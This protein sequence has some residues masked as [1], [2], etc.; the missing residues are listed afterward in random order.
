MLSNSQNKISMLNIKLQNLPSYAKLFVGITATLMLFVCLWAIIIFYVD[1]GLVD[2]NNLPAYLQQDQ[3]AEEMPADINQIY[4]D[5]EVIADDSLAE[6]APD[7]DSNFSEDTIVD[8]NP[9][10][11]AEKF[12]QSEEADEVD[13]PSDTA[14]ADESFDKQEKLRHN[15]GLAHTH[16]NGQTLLYFVIG[17]LFMFTTTKESIKKTVYLIFGIAVLTHAIG[18]SGEGFHWFFDNILALSGIT[19]LLVIPYMCFLIIIDLFKG[20]EE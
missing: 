17:F 1:K 7:W 9:V 10:A 5:A 14:I 20:R 18:L 8:K 6:L 4:D 15:I 16:I 2:E 19:L 13:N 12:I 11:L 3:V